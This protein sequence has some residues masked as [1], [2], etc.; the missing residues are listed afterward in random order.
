MPNYL[1]P[2]YLSFNVF[3]Y[4]VISYCVIVTYF[5]G[6]VR[7]QIKAS[8]GFEPDGVCVLPLCRILLLHRV[9]EDEDPSCLPTIR[10]DHCSWILLNSESAS[11]LRQ[12]IHLRGF[13]IL[14][15]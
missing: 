4:T 8:K 9:Y 15:R 1:P 5:C 12:D 3:P 6:P 13:L 2:A 11:C 14:N 10:I 7:D